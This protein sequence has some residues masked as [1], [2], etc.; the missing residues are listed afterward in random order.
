LTANISG[1]I[2]TRII[3]WALIL[4]ADLGGN[5]TYLG[6]APNIVAIG[7]L[8]Q[9]GIRVSFARFARE[10]IPVTILTLFIAT[11]WLLLRY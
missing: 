5:G 3:Y 2:E 11:L 6:S 1:G 10:G 9:A 4:G 8:A 7:L